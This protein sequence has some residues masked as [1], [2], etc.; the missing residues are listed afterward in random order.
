MRSLILFIAFL[1]FQN[2]WS[3]ELVVSEEI[4]SELETVQIKSDTTTYTFRVAYPDNYNPDKEY[5]CFLG[6]SGGDQSMKIVNY[7]YAAWFRSG[8]FKEYITILPVVVPA[9]D[10]TN[11]RDYGTPK[12]ENL[13]DVINENF[14]LKPQWLIAG[15]SNGGNAAFNFVAGFP[16]HFEGVIVA[17]GEVTAAMEPGELWSHLKVIIAYGTEDSKYWIKASKRSAK[18]L[19]K[20]VKSVQLIPL[21]GQGHILPVAFNVDK[22]YDPYFLGK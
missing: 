11:L 13:L 8:Y 19:K 20:V 16:S 5:K 17:P 2:V 4:L 1:G 15:T 3:Q 12:I 7:C 6:L 18:L 21:K 10:T 14:R 22:M 9:N